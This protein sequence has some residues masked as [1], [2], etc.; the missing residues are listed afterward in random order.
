M[1]RTVDALLD[2]TIV[3]GYTRLG[4]HLRKVSWTR[5]DPP[6]DARTCWSTTRAYCPAAAPRTPLDT[7]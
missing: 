3:P 5:D 2:R 7:N 1:I 4:Y 6:T